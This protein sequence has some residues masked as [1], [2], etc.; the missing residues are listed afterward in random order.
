MHKFLKEALD[1]YLRGRTWEWKTENPLMLNENQQYI[2]YN[3]GS[4]VLYAFSDLLGEE[5]FNQIIQGYIA[6]VAFQDAPYTTSLEF[7]E[8]LKN[9]SEERRVGKECRSWWSQ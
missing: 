5:Q 7:V 6:D 2:H 1:S 8:H 4:L 3:K 9:R